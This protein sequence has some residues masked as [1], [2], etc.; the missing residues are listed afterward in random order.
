VI[1]KNASPELVCSFLEKRVLI[2]MQLYLIQLFES[3]SIHKETNKF[4]NK[5]RPC[6]SAEPYGII[7]F[8]KI[9]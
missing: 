3:G 2:V 6:K 1:N 7:S 5:K 4:N 8:C 9:T